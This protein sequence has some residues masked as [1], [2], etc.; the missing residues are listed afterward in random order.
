MTTPGFMAETS[1]YKT[2]NNYRPSVGTANSASGIQPA[3]VPRNRCWRACC[4]HDPST[5]DFDCDDGCLQCCFHPSPR[6]CQ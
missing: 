4:W 3:L 1:V 6:N 2:E 5:G